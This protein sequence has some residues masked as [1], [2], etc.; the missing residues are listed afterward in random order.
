VLSLQH[1]I[2]EVVS[3][4]RLFQ[5]STEISDLPPFVLHSIYKAAVI[6]SYGV[7]GTANMDSEGYATPCKQKVANWTYEN[8]QITTFMENT[9][10]FRILLAKAN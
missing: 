10:K 7:G 5:A 4:S 1:L 3:I 8:L 9:N 2:E 6:V